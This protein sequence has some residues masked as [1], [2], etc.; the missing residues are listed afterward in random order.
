MLRSE[1]PAEEWAYQL[2]HAGDF[3][4]R[5]EAAKALATEHK[6]RRSRLLTALAK[7]WTREKDALA[8]AE[9][10]RQ[11]A[12]VGEPCRAALMEAAK[13]P[14]PRVKV[15]AFAGLT[16]LKLDPSLEAA[17]R[18]TIASTSEPYGARASALRA[19][20]QGKV[21]DAEDLVDAA[22]KETANHHALAR[23][24]LQGIMD[25]GGQKAREAAVIYSRPGQ[26]SVLRVVAI[27][28][29]SRQAKDDPQAETLL[30][31]LLDDPSQAIQTASAFA[32][33]SG[34]VTSSLPRLEEMLAK[35]GGMARRMLEPRIEELRKTSKGPA[36]E[37]DATREAVDLERQ[38]ADFELQAKDLRNRAEAIRI[39]AEK[40]RQ[41]KPQPGA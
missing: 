5:V 39:K 41:A 31:G 40:A 17:C 8:R 36:V 34:G 35:T 27:Q 38:A 10:V 18:S 22:L 19:L 25:R 29:L 3:P 30:V 12:A 13:D 2:E 23:S 16:P 24:A 20:V 33:A 14:E 1:K 11:V 4:G 26:P 32:L 15:A 9:I 7:A 6:A 21:K 37:S 28:A